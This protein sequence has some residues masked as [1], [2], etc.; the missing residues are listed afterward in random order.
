M[1][2]PVI[3]IT[4]S[5]NGNMFGLRSHYTSAMTE[6]GAVPLILPYMTDEETIKAYCDMSDGILFSGGV[7]IAPEYFGETPVNDTVE[8]CK[9]RDEFEFALFKAFYKT[10]KPILGICRGMQFINVALGGTLFQDIPGHKQTGDRWAVP[11][12]ARLDEESRL[13]AISGEKE[14]DV[15][16]FHHQAVKDVAPSLK[17][18]AHD[19][20]DGTVEAIETKENRFLIGVQWHPEDF[21]RE[22]V[23]AQ[24]LFAAFIAEANKN[25]G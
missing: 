17:I 15:N 19:A 1:K 9:A 22:N 11:Y 10:G 8:I 13:Y 21:Y 5:K 20:K 23:A 16:S 3:G 12:R 4:A 18:V 24:R 7:D 14:L 2:K 6:L 25:K